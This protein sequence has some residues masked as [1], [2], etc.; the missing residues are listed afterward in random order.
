MKEFLDVYQ[1]LNRD[2]L[3]LLGTVYAEN[4]QFID[5]AHEVNGLKEMT[6]YFAALYQNVESINFLFHHSLEVKDQG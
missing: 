3:H 2:N 6:A 4:V 5:P 1:K